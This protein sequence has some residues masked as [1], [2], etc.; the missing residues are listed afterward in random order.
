[1]PM[2]C[3]RKGC[4]LHVASPMIGRIKIFAPVALVKQKRCRDRASLV[5]KGSPRLR[6]RVGG[7]PRPRGA[8]GKHLHLSL[9][10]F[11]YER[12]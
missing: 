11:R 4:A 3:G 1:M 12:P 2:K 10:H 6:A 9:G 8:R 5:S 7:V